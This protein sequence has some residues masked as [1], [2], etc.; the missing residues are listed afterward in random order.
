MFL[1]LGDGV[2]FKGNV[3]PWY[4]PE[5][6]DYHLDRE[7]AANLVNLAL[8]TYKTNTGKMPSELFLHGKVQFNDDEWAG[9]RDA[10]VDKTNL[11]GVK[12]RESNDLKIIQKSKNASSQELPIF[13][14]SEKHIYGV[15]VTFLGCKHI[16]V[17]KGQT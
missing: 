14:P 8:E 2:V 12:I 11:V 9:F 5:I 15:K 1:D 17:A 4:N 13:I 7:A 6:G 10:V 16:P 3:G